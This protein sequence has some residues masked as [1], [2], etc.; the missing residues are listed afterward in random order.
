MELAELASKE[1][2]PLTI[3]AR[4]GKYLMETRGLNGQLPVTEI[5]PAE[6]QA[7]KIIM[8]ALCTISGASPKWLEAVEN[9]TPHAWSF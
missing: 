1:Q 8:V 3:L 7:T 5:N 4:A 2:D 6:I 9:Q